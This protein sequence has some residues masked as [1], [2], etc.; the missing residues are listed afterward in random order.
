MYWTVSSAVAVAVI[1]KT[2]LYFTTVTVPAPISPQYSEEKP[3]RMAIRA[4]PPTSLQ[5]CHPDPER[6]RRGRTCFLR[7]TAA[8]V[9]PNSFTAVATAGY[10]ERQ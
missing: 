7:R 3:G 5:I 4:A 8:T 2:W 6:S 9:P 10:D 1:F